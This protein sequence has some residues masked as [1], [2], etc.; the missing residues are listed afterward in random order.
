VESGLEIAVS[1]SSELS[2]N[3]RTKIELKVTECRDISYQHM[4]KVVTQPKPQNASLSLPCKSQ[5]NAP[6]PHQSPCR[7][8]RRTS[9]RRCHHNALCRQC[10]CSRR[11]RRTN[12]TLN[13]AEVS[14][15]LRSNESCLCMSSSSFRRCS[16]FAF[17]PKLMNW[18]PRASRSNPCLSSKSPNR[19]RTTSGSP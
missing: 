8:N 19:S 14:Y 17:L 12:C 9:S 16:P 5:L 6:G 4:H 15:S 18:I 7:E 1:L 11:Q 10:R 13:P 2:D 3:G